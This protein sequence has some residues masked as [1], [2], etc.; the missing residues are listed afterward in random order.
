MQRIVR[1]ELKKKSNI[2][3]RTAQEKIYECEYNIGEAVV[4]FAHRFI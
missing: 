2:K 3:K 1:P 4:A